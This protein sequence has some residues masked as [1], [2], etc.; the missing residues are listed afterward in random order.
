ML[1]HFYQNVSK[2]LNLWSPIECVVS[3]PQFHQNG[4][5]FFNAILYLVANEFIICT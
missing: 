3:K 2:P 1:L 5:I 4:K